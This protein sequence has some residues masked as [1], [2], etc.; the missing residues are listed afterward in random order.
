MK[1]E[2]DSPWQTTVEIRVPFHD[3]DPINVAWYGSVYKYFDRARSQLMRE[4]G[5]DKQAMAKSG[6]IWPVIE[7]HCRHINFIRGETL[8][9]VTAGIEDYEQCLRTGYRVRGAEDDTRLATGWTVQ[10]AVDEP[11]GEMKL[12]TPEVLKRRLREAAE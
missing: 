4:I 6:Y 2:I 7:S 1:R 11:S 10:V 5:Y 3:L 9:R 12:D 8:I